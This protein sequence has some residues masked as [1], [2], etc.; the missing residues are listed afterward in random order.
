MLEIRDATPADHSDYVRLFAEL[1]V[2]DRVASLERFVAELMART[3]VATDDGR[4]VGYALCEVLAEVGYIRNI[5]SAPAHRRSGIGYALMQA[6]RQRFSSHGATAWCLNVKP[7]NAAAIGLYERCGMRTAYRSCALR[8]ASSVP[9]PPV[10]AEVT[11]APIPSHDDEAVERAFGLLRGQLASTRA[12]PSRE[13]LPLWRGDER[14]GVGLFSPS[15]PGAFPFRVVEPAL[16]ASFLALLRPRAPADAAY[17]QVGV[18][19]DDALRAA[20][21]ALGGYVELEMLHLRG[22]L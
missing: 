4:I 18:E 1:G 10:P 14:V 21:L 11:L 2:D 19:D 22:G 15:I 17:L 6:L 9:L 12:R 20:L 8:V 16:G 13:V 5:V 3:I 7:D